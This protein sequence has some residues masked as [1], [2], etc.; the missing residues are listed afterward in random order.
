MSIFWLTDGWNGY[1]LFKLW[2]YDKSLDRTVHQNSCSLEKTWNFGA[3]GRIR[4]CEPL[5]ERISHSGAQAKASI[6]SPSP[7]TWLGYRSLQANETYSS[8]LLIVSHTKRAQVSYSWYF[9]IW[10]TASIAPFFIVMLIR[11]EIR[12]LIQTPNF[13]ETLHQKNKSAPPHV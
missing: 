10:T 8:F 5:R 3:T 13:K 9:F 7:L 1:F 11:F 12:I 2:L 4:T 6:L